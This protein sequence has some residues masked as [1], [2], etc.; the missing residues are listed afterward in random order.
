LSWHP[1]SQLSLGN[2]EV[3]G[4]GCGN[5]GKEGQWRKNHATKTDEN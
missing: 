3:H 4:G 2:W 1:P 5:A